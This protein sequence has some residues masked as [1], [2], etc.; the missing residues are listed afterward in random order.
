MLLHERI[1]CPTTASALCGRPLPAVTSENTQVPQTETVLTE[2]RG[3]N[4]TMSQSFAPTN[5]VCGRRPTLS[6]LKEI[7]QVATKMTSVTE[8]FAAILSGE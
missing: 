2:M 8:A 7:A 6:K 5:A 4:L 1:V 3:V